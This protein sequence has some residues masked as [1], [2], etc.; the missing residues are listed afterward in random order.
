MKYDIEWE[1]KDGRLRRTQ[2]SASNEDEACEHVAKIP[3]CAIVICVE[4]IF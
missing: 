3:E 4:E 2:L 1:D